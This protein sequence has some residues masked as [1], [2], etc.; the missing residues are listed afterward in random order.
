MGQWS[1]LY[2]NTDNKKAML[3]NVKADSY[4][5]VP[6]PFQAK[7]GKYI[8]ETEYDGYGHMG[9]YDRDEK[10]LRNRKTSVSA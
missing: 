2:A 5:L 4:L 7:Y 10:D 3:D 9:G 6:P 1:Y 8:L